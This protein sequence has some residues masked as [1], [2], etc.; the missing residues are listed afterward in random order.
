MKIKN[1]FILF[2]LSIF[3]LSCQGA[4][5]ALQTKKRSKSNEEFLVKKKTPL[6]AP[7]D[8]NKLPV[9]LDEE[10][11]DDDDADDPGIKKILNID[12]NETKNQNSSISN[13][14]TEQTIL[15]NISN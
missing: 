14:T 2:L 15:E 13:T 12:E 4:K 3:L 9:P 10:N 7:P 5:D 6:T 1:L 11:L 8:I